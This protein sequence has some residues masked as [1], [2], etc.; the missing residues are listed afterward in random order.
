MAQLTKVIYQMNS[1]ND[2][3][4]LMLKQYITAYEK[5][6]DQIVNECNNI[7]SKYKDQIDNG[8]K[9]DEFNFE[10]KRI[11]TTIDREKD[12]S[13]REFGI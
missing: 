12:M 11:Q 10:I 9:Q 7:I 8:N 6:M 5:E 4:D 2:E 13:K 1:K 3:N